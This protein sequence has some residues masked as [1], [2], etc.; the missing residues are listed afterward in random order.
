VALVVF[1]EGE[2]NTVEVS[3]L[4]NAEFERLKTD[5]RLSTMYM[6]M[7]FNQGDVVE[8]ALRNLVVGGLL[9]AGL[10]GAVLFFFLRRIR[11][12][13]IITLSIPIS[14]FIA[15]PSCSSPANR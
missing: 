15:W 14:L 7:L 9:G 12:T 5:P 6:E 10:A 3:R 13:A 1:K 11:L 4:L 2:A 8:D